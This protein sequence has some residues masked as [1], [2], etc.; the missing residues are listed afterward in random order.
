MEV[1]AR[2]AART[3]TSHPESTNVFV[4]IFTSR[5]MFGGSSELARCGPRAGSNRARV[6]KLLPLEDDVGEEQR[7]SDTHPDDSL[8][9]GLAQVF[10]TGDASDY[11][12]FKKDDRDSE[13]AGHP[14]AVLLDISP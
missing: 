14:L 4:V 7:E 11:A 2:R 9:D 1:P 6:E 8:V 10:P 13:T 5:G 3:P 12:D